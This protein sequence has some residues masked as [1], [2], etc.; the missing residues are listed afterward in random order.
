MKKKKEVK[1]LSKKEVV[2]RMISHLQ[3]MSRVMQIE[4]L[5]SEL[6]EREISAF[7]LS[8]DRAT[9]CAQNMLNKF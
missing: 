4:G 7:V 5:F 9:T 3:D 1:M 6:N 8:V 2:E